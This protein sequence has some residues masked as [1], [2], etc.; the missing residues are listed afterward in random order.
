MNI[1]IPKANGLE[2]IELPLEY[3]LIAGAVI[4]FLALFVWLGLSGYT[5]LIYRKWRL[6]NG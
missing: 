6:K 3:R 5:N 1:D 4:L 2:A